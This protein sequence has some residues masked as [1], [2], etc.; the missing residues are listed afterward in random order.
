MD[1]VVLFLLVGTFGWWI[2]SIT[3][4]VGYEPAFES[5]P[6]EFDMMFGIVDYSATSLLDLSEFRSPT[7]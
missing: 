3:R 1:K 2:G 4:P 7:L 6:S 5:E